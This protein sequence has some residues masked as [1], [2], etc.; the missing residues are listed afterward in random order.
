MG[1]AAAFYGAYKLDAVSLEASMEPAKATL[2]KLSFG[3]ADGRVDVS[4]TNV[5][6]GDGGH[7]QL[8]ATLSQV[9]TTRLLAMA[10]ADASMLV[11]NMNA[12]ATLEMTG[13]N[14]QDG[15]GAS[16]GQAVF[17]MVG[18]QM[19]RQLLQLASIDMRLLLRKGQGTLPVVCFLAVTNMR[20]GVASVAPFRLKTGNGNLSGGGQV[21]LRRDFIDLY[22]RSESKSTNFWALDVPVH[23][24]GSLAAP[25]VRPSIRSG[26]PALNARGSENMRA[27][28]P[29]LR[30]MIAAK[31][32]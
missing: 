16:R 18:G 7:L 6:A 24:T 3:F 23:I 32:C 5:T 27:L 20:D 21:D 8:D 29:G 4:G 28:T 1:A 19:S 9:S 13:T 25:Q 14:T 12:R 22:L 17:S 31:N 10:D 2:G 30:Q 11:G 15:L 26:A